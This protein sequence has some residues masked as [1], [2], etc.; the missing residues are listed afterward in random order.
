MDKTCGDCGH[1]KD[2]SEFYDKSRPDGENLN[3]SLYSSDCKVRIRR[4]RAE[5]VRTRPGKAKQA[6][7]KQHL[8]KYNLTPEGY[9][10][11]FT[12]Q[13][14]VCPGC[15][16]HQNDF[17]RRLVVDHDHKTGKV[18]GL[19]CMTCNLILG[20][21][22]DDPFVLSNLIKYLDKQSPELADNNTNVVE[23]KFPKKAG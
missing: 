1:V 23:C 10:E 18:R 4:Q 14:G 20:Y 11:L 3:L 6:D 15:E 17:D 19:L 12:N 16:R 5:Y 21:A 9:N 8:K 22:M 13:Q 2:V 7:R